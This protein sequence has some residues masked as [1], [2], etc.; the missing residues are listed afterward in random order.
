M[1]YIFVSKTAPFLL[2]AW[3]LMA[4]TG[5]RKN[6][7]DEPRPTQSV[8]EEEVFRSEAG[9]RSYFSGIYSNMRT[10]W[11]P[12]AAIVENSTDA[13][14]YNSIN[15]ARINK[16]IDIINPMVAFVRCGSGIVTR[17]VSLPTGELALP[18]SF[19]TK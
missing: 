10:Q 2:L 15:L 19:Y 14:G 12:I 9:V 11:R 17:T 13:W 7:L 18:G 5:C 3:I 4:A 1:K 6:F 8:T 16:G